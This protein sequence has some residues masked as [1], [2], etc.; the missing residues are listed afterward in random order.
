ME[1]NM[2][3]L[4]LIQFILMFSLKSTSFA[5]TAPKFDLAKSN[6]TIERVESL[7][8]SGQHFLATLLATNSAAGILNQIGVDQTVSSIET[9]ISEMRQQV[10]KE[11]TTQKSGIDI[12]FGLLTG[13]ARQTYDVAEII[14]VNPEVV[15]QAPQKIGSDFGKL[16]AQLVSYVNQNERA[17]VYAKAFVVLALK[18]SLQLTADERQDIM[19]VVKRTVQLATRLEFKAVQN[20]SN[21][22]TTNYVNRSQDTGLSIGGWLFSFDLSDRKEQ[23]AYT[24]KTCQS[25]SMRAS[26][27]D[28][29]MYSLRIAQMDRLVKSYMARVELR[30][31]VDAKAEDSPMWGLEIIPTSK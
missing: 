10:V 23:F 8:K 25:S 9:Q 6:Q 18:S 19:A 17:I 29:Q 13:G 5:Q 1:T 11:R 21:C 27:I 2:K 24:S 7:A 15:A 22:V 28:A 14:T 20:I 4:I 30:A 26:V 31:V 12:L 3:N 16:Q